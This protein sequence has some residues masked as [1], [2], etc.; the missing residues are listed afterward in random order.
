MKNEH[1]SAKHADTKKLQFGSKVLTF[2]VR[3]TKSD[4]HFQIHIL[5][6]VP[7]FPRLHSLLLQF[8]CSDYAWLFYGH[9]VSSKMPSLLVS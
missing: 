7:T 6:N 5:Y 1:S 4:G 9:A 8:L 3:H 2:V